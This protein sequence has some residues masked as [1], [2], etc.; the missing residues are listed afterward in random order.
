MGALCESNSKD[1]HI[2][3][4]ES[5]VIHERRGSTRKVPKIVSTVTGALCLDEDREVAEITDYYVLGDM[6]G[7]GTFG[8]VRLAKHRDT[9]T[10]CAIKIIDKS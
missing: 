4:L 10:I 6:L 3:S 5:D 8:T 2:G 1:N 9:D 7:E